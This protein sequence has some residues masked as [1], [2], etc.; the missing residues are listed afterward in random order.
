[1]SELGPTLHTARLILRPPALEDFDAFAAFCADDIVMRYLGGTQ[2]RTVAWRSF[3]GAAGSWAVQGFGMFSVFERAGG[4]WVG[5]IGPMY[6]EGWP[7]TEVGWG[8]VQR[9]WGRG[10]AVEAASAAMDWAADELGWSEI[11]HTI[12]PAN[13]ASRKVAQTL[14]SRV[15][16]TAILPAPI[17]H[18]IVDVWGQSADAWRARRR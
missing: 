18:G 10:Y 16:R 15:L 14:G 3:L 1:M 11:V 17:E 6:H 5:R 8:V 13:V 9:R 2:A 7:G 12:D 4:Q